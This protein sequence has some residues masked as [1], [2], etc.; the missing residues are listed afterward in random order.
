VVWSEPVRL[1]TMPA[2]KS[3]TVDFTRED[4]ALQIF[5][6]SPLLSSEAAWQGIQLKHY[7]LP[8]YETP[9]YHPTQHTI[10]IHL[11]QPL[12]EEHWWGDEGFQKKHLTYGDVSIYPA[13]CPQRQ[14]CRQDREFIDL[15]LD[16]MLFVEAAAGWMELKYINLPHLTIPDPLIYQMVLALKMELEFATGDRDAP[17]GHSLYVE[18]IV[19]A[20]LLHLLRHYSTRQVNLHTSA[21]A[22]GLPPAK[23]RAALAYLQEHLD[24]D[25]TLAELA[26]VV[27]ISPHYFASLFKQSM[28]QTPHHYWTTCRVERAKQLLVQSEQSIV[29]ISH[30][31]GFQSQSHFT[32]VFFKHTRMTPK[33]Y[34]DSR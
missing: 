13:N 23:L 11:G 31:V 14:R 4:S 10:S 22:K 9:E 18:S 33:L 20:L 15:Y 19:N 5:P 7:R 24:R 3:V 17:T 25:L 8:A 21:D 34:R 12:V 16:P 28:G 30:E 1:E 2:A 32:K 27:Q 29:E 26:A 6:R